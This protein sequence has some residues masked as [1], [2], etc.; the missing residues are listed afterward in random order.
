MRIMARELVLLLPLWGSLGCDL[1]FPIH[2]DQPVGPGDAGAREADSPGPDRQGP[3]VRAPPP[4]IVFVQNAAG[5][6]PGE[7]MSTEL[8]VPFDKAN[9]AGDLVLVSVGWGG[10]STGA[11]P[12]VSDSNENAPYRHVFQNPVSWAAGFAEDLFYAGPVAAGE[13]TVT[14]TFPEVP[15]GFFEVR[16]FEYSGVEALDVAAEMA[17]DGTWPV[18]ELSSGT[19]TTRA[20]DELMFAI[21]QVTFGGGP[22]GCDPY[23]AGKFFRIRDVDGGGQVVA[24]DR[25]LG[26]PG[27]YGASATERCEAGAGMSAPFAML[28]ATF[29]PA[30]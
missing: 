16:A 25:V 20:A 22:T 17:S 10:T 7:P 13:N 4:P 5:H 18:V 26:P 9:H 14:V 1:L 27:V 21:G 28:M 19:A 6:A 8:M 2:D 29:K 11:A 12:K 3:D 15:L 30:K 23:G 24:E